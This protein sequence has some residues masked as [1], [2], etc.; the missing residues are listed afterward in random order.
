MQVRIVVAGG[1]AHATALRS[2]FTDR[3]TALASS[4][5]RLW[6]FD[7]ERSDEDLLQEAACIA[8]TGEPSRLPF[9][10]DDTHAAFNWVVGI[11]RKKAMEWR[12]A[13]AYRSMENWNAEL[14]S[15][16]L[17]QI[18]LTLQ[19]F[20]GMRLRARLERALAQIPEKYLTPIL[21]RYVEADDISFADLG[22]I[23]GCTEGA[24]KMRVQ[25]G[26]AML[27]ALLS[28]DDD[29]P[30]HRPGRAP[31]LRL[32]VK[33]GFD[34]LRTHLAKRS[35]SDPE[36]SAAYLEA[37]YR[38]AQSVVASHR[39]LLPS[40]HVA[41]E[42]ARDLMAYAYNARL[43]ID[44]RLM[45]RLTARLR[46]Q[47]WRDRH[48]RGGDALMGKYVGREDAIALRMESVSDDVLKEVRRGTPPTSE[49]WL[50]PLLRIYGLM[51]AVRREEP[52]HLERVR[53]RKAIVLGSPAGLPRH[54]THTRSE[55]NHEE[56]ATPRGSDEAAKCVAVTRQDTPIR[57][58]RRADLLLAGDDSVTRNHI[59][60]LIVT[61]GRLALPDTGRGDPAGVTRDGDAKRRREHGNRA[62]HAAP[63]A[64]SRRSPTNPA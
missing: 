22:Q 12:R 39:R 58:S 25:R 2:L 64:S 48:L 32:T 49:R 11:M 3:E 63:S 23:L 15:R 13:Y 35:A 36:D 30:P 41:S 52:L 29:P 10:P 17:A 37:I 62:G 4:A 8:L 16:T 27:K 33:D 14:R 28:D 45:S 7:G 46:G 50:V 1:T 21:A 55:N 59:K 5:R 40:P 56:A 53:R 18:E 31:A 43:D 9:D 38:A 44:E 24:A 47:I 19:D 51:L 6:P 54:T 61:S 26:L 20:D 34:A 42:Y 60:N 57:G